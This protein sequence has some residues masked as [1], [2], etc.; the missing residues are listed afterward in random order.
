[1]NQHVTEQSKS[2]A[3]STA[4]HDGVPVVA[5]TGEIDMATSW[6]VSDELATQLDR[7]PPVLV[8]D[9]LAVSF[10]GSAGIQVLLDARARAER[11]QLTLMLVSAHPVVSRPLEVTAVAQLFQIYPTLPEALRALWPV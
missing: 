10:F 4:V 9:L 8:I 2:I 6:L 1:M 11:H 3:V 7:R 5:V